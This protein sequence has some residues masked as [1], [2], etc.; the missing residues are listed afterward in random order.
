MNYTEVIFT[1]KPASE[2]ITEIL[3]AQLAEIGFESFVESDEGLTAYIPEA[4]FDITQLDSQIESFPLDVEINY[5]FKEIENKNWNEEWEQHFFKPIVFDDQCIIRSSFHLVDATYEYEILIEPKMAFGTGHHQTT[6]LVIREMLKMDFKNQ[7]ALD[8]GCG[9]AVLAILASMKGAKEILAID[10]DEWAYNNA[11]ENV[12]LNNIHNITVKQGGAEQIG[13]QT[14]DTIIANINRNILLQDIPHYAKAL[15][16][17][18]A[19]ILSGFYTEDIP[20]LMEIC[21]AHFIHYQHHSEM[22]NWVGL[23][24]RK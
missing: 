5:S 10:I 11:L 20:A 14:F 4:D 24:C 23:V 18:G 17:G 3:A 19:L 12:E 9:T 13:N 8:M 21:N 16:P 15:N 6:S 22:D 1:C 7:T 2:I